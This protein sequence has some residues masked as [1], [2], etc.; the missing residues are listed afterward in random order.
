MHNDHLIIRLWYVSVRRA[1]CKMQT[2]VR[3]NEATEYTSSNGKAVNVIYWPNW[4]HLIKV[5]LWPTNG[6]W[7]LVTMN[8]RRKTNEKKDMLRI[9]L[10]HRHVNYVRNREKKKWLRRIGIRFILTVQCQFACEKKLMHI[11]TV[12]WYSTGHY[13]MPRNKLDRFFMLQSALSMD[14]FALVLHL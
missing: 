1:N 8:E 9:S 14:V 7:P 13:N 6:H 2:N 12:G 3:R 5:F 10:R 11:H 4:R